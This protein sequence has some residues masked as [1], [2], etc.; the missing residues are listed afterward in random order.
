MMQIKRYF[1]F[2]CF[3]SQ[4]TL[5]VHHGM[6]ISSHKRL[7]IFSQEYIL[8]PAWMKTFAGIQEL[9]TQGRGVLLLL[10][11]HKAATYIIVIFPCVIRACVR[12]CVDSPTMVCIAVCTFTWTSEHMSLTDCCASFQSSG[13]WMPQCS[14]G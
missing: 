8:M 13:M 2:F 14:T 5:Q 10:L 4:H 1:C 11:A 12:L 9:T 6:Q 3:I 7:I